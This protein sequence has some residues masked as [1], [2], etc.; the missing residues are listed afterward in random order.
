LIVDK[1][2]TLITKPSMMRSV[3]RLRLI[4]R[5]RSL[6][7]IH[8]AYFALTMKVYQGKAQDDRHAER[9]AKQYEQQRNDMLNNKK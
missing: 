4:A 9:A 7:F 2:E 3:L 8:N 1:A 6:I 5:N